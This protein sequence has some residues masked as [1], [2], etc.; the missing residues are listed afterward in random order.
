M[1]ADVTQYLS[2]SIDQNSEDHQA[3]RNATT[4][5]VTTVKNA[6]VPLNPKYRHNENRPLDAHSCTVPLTEE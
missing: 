3:A 4:G 5:D 2:S 1:N 6:A